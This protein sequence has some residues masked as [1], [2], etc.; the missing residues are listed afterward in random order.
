[1]VR[2][3]LKRVLNL[4]LVVTMWRAI[5]PRPGKT[6]LRAPAHSVFDD[7]V[8]KFTGDQPIPGHDFIRRTAFRTVAA[9]RDDSFEEA[10]AAF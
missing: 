10:F 2:L 1:L 7:R 3:A 6:L 8:K 9:H 4:V 5:L